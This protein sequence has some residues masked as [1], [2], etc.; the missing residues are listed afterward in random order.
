MHRLTRQLGVN[1]MFSL[2]AWQCFGMY[3]PP[4]G[5]QFGFLHL[6]MAA[7]L[8]PDF[9]A[10][11]CWL[12]PIG[13][14]SSSDPPYPPTGKNNMLQI[15]NNLAMAVNKQHAVKYICVI[16]GSSCCLVLPPFPKPSNIFFPT[17]APAH[18]RLSCHLY[19]FP[20][21]HTHMYCGNNDSDKIFSPS[22]LFP[23]KL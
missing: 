13:R 16:F 15:N 18:L 4:W 3:L 12:Q 22:L 11:H 17:C 14:V 6:S 8:I 2:A 9:P 5:I 20:T 19:G 23:F 1:A 7:W 10:V 21:T